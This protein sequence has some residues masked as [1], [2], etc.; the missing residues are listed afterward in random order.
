MVFD[1]ESSKGKQLSEN[2]YCEILFYWREFDRQIRISG[3][4]TRLGSDESDLYF[5]QR[6]LESQAAAVASRQSQPVE[7]RAILEEHF[8]P[9]LPGLKKLDWS[10]PKDGEGIG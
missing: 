8:R 10:D 3:K 7:T 4:V 6:P 9:K 5:N 2:D 1:Y